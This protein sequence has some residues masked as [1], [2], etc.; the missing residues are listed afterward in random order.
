VSASHHYEA[1]SRCRRGGAIGSP[2]MRTAL[3]VLYAA[4][5]LSYL[6]WRLGF[7]LNA[8]HPL[9]AGLFLCAEAFGVLASLVFYTLILHRGDPPG[10]SAPGRPYTVDVLIA[11]YNEDTDLLRTTAVAAR[12]MKG[13]HRTWICDDGRRTAAKALAREIGVGYITRPDNEHYKAGNL[14]HALSVIEGDLVL[15][16]DADHVPRREMLERLVGYFQDESLALVQTPQLFYNVDSYQH[17]VLAGRRRL[18]HEASLFHHM[19]Q[20]GAGRLNAAFF[21]GTGAMLRRSALEEVG[22]FA[23]GSITEDIHTSMRLHAA[24]YR[25]LYVDEALGFLLA[26]DTPFAFARQRLR[27]AQGAMQILRKENPLRKRGLDLWQRIGYMNSLAGYLSAYQHLVLYLA[28]GLYLM[29]GMSPIAVDPFVGFPIFV[30]WIAQGLLVYKLL[31]APHA[32]LFLSECYKMLTVSIHIFAS[33]TL[34]RPEGLSFRVTPKGKHGGLPL[35]LVMPAAFLFLFNLTGVGIGLTRLVRGGPYL[36][37]LV[38]TTFF[39]AWF[40]LAGALA[41]VHAW[42]RR[43]VEEPFAFPVSLGARVWWKVRGGGDGEPAAVPAQVR[44]LNHRTAY[45]LMQQQPEP[46]RE[47]LLDLSKAGLDLPVAAVVDGH[48]PAVGAKSGTSVVKL[49][50]RGLQPLARDALDRFLFNTALPRFFAG[51]H[52]APPGP[53]PESVP[54][55]A[56]SETEGLDFLEV[57]IGIL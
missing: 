28:P 45:A 51:F 50:L 37:A 14:N 48:E 54:E 40:A 27:W 9:Y 16:L 24:G 20:P 3:F 18:W 55:G 2:R 29:A 41:L 7:T 6:V 34:L 21:V 30:A 26:P 36:G 13:P 52:E 11:T 23:T 42:E 56:G 53:P 4:L 57:R 47:V 35:A 5:A 49:S 44:R 31:A 43:G 33:A 25:S 39:S 15:V 10:P 46:G 19:M 12:D 32:R 17:H 1:P 38:L 22:G 8:E